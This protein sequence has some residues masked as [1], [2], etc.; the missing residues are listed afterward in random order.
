MIAVIFDIYE[1][2]KRSIQKEVFLNS[3]FGHTLFVYY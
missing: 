1:G 2:L 3:E